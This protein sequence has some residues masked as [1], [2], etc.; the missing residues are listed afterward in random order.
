MGTD[1]RWI[2]WPAVGLRWPWPGPGP[3]GGPRY[4]VL[5]WGYWCVTV[6]KVVD[7]MICLSGLGI[8]GRL[9]KKWVGVG[10]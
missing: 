6:E 4:A 8:D 1:G 9:G 2:G 10:C 5:G 3:T 7:L